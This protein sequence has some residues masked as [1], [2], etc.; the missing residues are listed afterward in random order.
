MAYL[1]IL[2]IIIMALLLGI[3]RGIFGDLTHLLSALAGFVLAVIFTPKVSAALT[4]FIRAVFLQ[5]SGLTDVMERILAALLAPAVFALVFIAAFTLIGLITHIVNN[6]VKLSGKP[7]LAV[8]LAINLISGLLIAYGVLLP[9]GYY[10]HKASAIGG[11]AQ[12][13]GADADISGLDLEKYGLPEFIYRPLLKQMSGIKLE[14]GIVSV[15][16]L[17]EVFHTLS[18]MDIEDP[19]TR[20]Q[21]VERL[22]AD[23]KADELYGAAIQMIADQ[24]EHPALSQIMKADGKMSSKLNAFMAASKFLSLLSQSSAEN[25]QTIRSMLE[26]ADNETYDIAA[27]LCDFDTLKM[28]HLNLGYNAPLIAQIMRE[29][30]ILED[31]SEASV[32]REAAALT[33]LISPTGA[34]KLPFNFNELDSNELA[35]CI[36]DST[37]LQNAI[38]KVTE[39]GNVIDPCRMSGVVFNNKAS[40]IIYALSSK[41]GVSPGSELHKSLMAYFGITEV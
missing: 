16:D 21:L 6:H 3:R 24:I 40:T 26:T 22:K 38:I 25:E 14:N 10:P 41:Y 8:R 36:N 37:I 31:R 13:L 29:I 18:S 39:G 20:S 19:E 15:D 27:M 11:L 32:S 30:G 33:Y 34:K 23:P 17:I 1:I 2:F 9:L 28:Y 12:T 7:R 5:G 35:R 4:G